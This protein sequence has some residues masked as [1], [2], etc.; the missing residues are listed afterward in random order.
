[1]SEIIVWFGRIHCASYL[2]RE[3]ESKHPRPLRLEKVRGGTN[4]KPTSRVSTVNPDEVALSII[5]LREMFGTGPTGTV[6]G[7]VV[8]GIELTSVVVL[9]N[10]KLFDTVEVGVLPVT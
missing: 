6:G 3:G 10:A 4:R 9:F 8:F 5:E 2:S 7:G 1:M